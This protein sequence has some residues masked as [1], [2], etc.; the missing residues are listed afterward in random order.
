MEIQLRKHRPKCPLI[1]RC[2]VF[3]SNADTTG[4]SK[5]TRGPTSHPKTPM[6][7]QTFLSLMLTAGCIAAE[8]SLISSFDSESPMKGWTSKDNVKCAVS[9][10]DD[11]DRKNALKCEISFEKFTY[12]WVRKGNHAPGDFD[13]AKQSGLSLWVRAN[14]TIGAT[15]ALTFLDAE[16]QEKRFIAPISVTDKWTQVKVPFESLKSEKGSTPIT[17]E[18]ANKCNWFTVSVSKKDAVDAVLWIDD[19]GSSSK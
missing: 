3:G 12:A 13:P 9:P 15:V 5:P 17:A 14:K 18:E 10:T 4:D 11:A 1:H 19:F 6:I 2:Q 16:K 8:P 7:K